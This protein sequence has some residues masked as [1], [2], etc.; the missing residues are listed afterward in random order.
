MRPEAQNF[1]RDKKI[2]SFLSN[3]KKYFKPVKVILFGSRAG[4]DWLIESDYDF[5][6]VS[7]KFQNMDIFERMK[8]VFVKCG[9]RFAADILYYTPEEFEKKRKEIGIVREAVKR[10]VFLVG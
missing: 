1:K 2:D 6:V 4:E 5:I 9:V 10:G 3:L 7:D 8:S